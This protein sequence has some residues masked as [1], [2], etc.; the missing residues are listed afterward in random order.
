LN[1]QEKSVTQLTEELIRIPSMTPPGDVKAIANLIGDFGNGNGAAVELQEVEENRENC[2]LT[3]DFGPGKTLLFNAHMDVNNPAG[4]HWSFQPFEPFCSAGKLYGVGSCD[5]KGSLAAMLKA[6]QRIVD[7]P[8][9][10]KG[11]LLFTAVMGEEA[12]GIG[13]LHMAQKGIHADGV[14]VGEP[15]ELEIC[16]AHKGTYIRKFTFTGRAVHSASSQRGINAIHHAARFAV[17]YSELGAELDRHPHPI[18]GPAN[19]SV[20]LMGG[21]TRQNTI[22]QSA[23]VVCDRRLLP[24]EDSRKADLEVAVIFTRLKE[25]IPDLHPVVTEVLAATVPSQT[26]G[27]EA[28]VQ[29]GLN[30]VRA[31]KRKESTPHGFN[32]GCDMSKFVTIAHI[33]TIICGPGSLREAHSPDEFVEIEQLRRAVDIYERI[34]REFLS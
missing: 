22:P 18:L 24:G 7:R 12:G 17:L 16:T 30:A 15:T 25:E 9:G 26:L 32:A 13:A 5:T 23:F 27:G 33:P 19:A 28:I 11:K 4:Q 34:I 31:V 21:G 29:A 20:T 6:V 14:V 3:F 8:E 10:I 2:I 1:F